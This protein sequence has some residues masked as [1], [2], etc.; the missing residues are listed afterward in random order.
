MA[1]VGIVGAGIIGTASAVNLIDRGHSVT[2]FERD[3]DRRHASV[4]NAGVLAVPEIDPLARPEMVLAAPK[5]LLDPL[6]PLTVRWQDATRLAPWLLAFLAAS[7]PSR[8]EESK[9]ALTLLMR[10]ARAEHRRLSEMTG[11]PLHVRETGALHVFDSTAR[12]DRAFSAEAENA[13]I[14]GHQVERLDARATR[15][16]APALEGR[17]AGAVFCTGYGM[18]PDP[19]ALLEGLRAYIRARGALHAAKVI[20]VRPQQD[21][22]VIRDESGVERM[23]DKVLIS[24]GVWSRILVKALGLKVLL[25]TERGYNTTWASAPVSL[26]MPVF[27]SE[28]GFCAS[29]LDIGLRIG[30]AVEMAAPEAPANYARAAAMRAKMRR[31]VPA[32]PEEGGVEWMG[33]RPSTPD[34]VPVIGLVPQD[35]RI[36][37][38]FG[39]GHLGVTL[40]AVTGR[41]V[42][43][44]LT[45]DGSPQ[46]NPFSIERF[47]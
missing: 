27:F 32:L 31:Y 2:L 43:D 39:H 34:S 47:Q 8:A 45:G 26:P 21:G 3:P 4:G 41:R 18:F 14:L 10:E 17:F 30:G 6:G 7:R 5:W 35:R 24:A 15:D 37:L 29:P 46:E 28:H 11:L 13:R 1:S 12:L 23:F 42:A 33:C 38:A 25:E 36:A 40:S 44:L 19:P 22:V 20:A 16:R 9:R